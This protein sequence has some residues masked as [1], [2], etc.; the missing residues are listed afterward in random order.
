MKRATN[1][2]TDGEDPRPDEAAD[3]APEAEGKT[4][5]QKE[6]SAGRRPRR[7][8]TRVLI[9]AVFLVILFIGLSVLLYPAVSNYVNEK[10]QSRVINIYDENL[11][12]LSAVD[13][14]AY[15]DAARDYNAHLAKSKIP[16]HDAFASF[17]GDTDKTGNYWKLLDLDGSGVMG[18]I[19]I[20]KIDVKLPI[21]HGSDEAILQAGVGHMQGSSLPVGGES[22]HVVLSAH[23]GLPSAEY[24]TDIDQLTNGDTFEL[25]VLGEVL[26]Y[27][28][29]QILTVLPD[30]LDALSI[31]PGEDHVTLVTCTPYGV[32]TYRLLVR[33]TRTENA[34]TESET[35]AEPM[36]VQ[37]N[38]EAV[39]PPT[40]FQKAREKTV[41][42]FGAGFEKL[43]T[44]FVKASE[45]GMDRLG[46]KY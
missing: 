7:I 40:W 1:N 2:L 34:E 31:I 8:L 16:V 24:F 26:T 20:D 5:N 25:H 19:V 36:T 12:A 45:W 17:E 32:N 35:A 23:T 15:L 18:Y 38:P 43:A 28:V 37:K 22:T 29:D 44:W 27:R 46:I 13:Y 30:K 42:A 41:A 10:N 14:T 21:Y 6:P 39:Q 9:L 33:G 11:A 4:E 3:P